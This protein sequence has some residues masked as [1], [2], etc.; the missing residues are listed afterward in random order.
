MRQAI[1]PE[2]LAEAARATGFSPAIRAGDFLFLTGATGAAA[3]GTM[4]PTAPEQAL[5]ALGKV[6]LVLAEEGATE[7][8]IVELTSYHTDIDADFSGI[9]GVLDDFFTAPLPAWTAVE[10]A[11]L[12]RPGARVEFRVVAHHPKRGSR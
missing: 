5:N 11:G 6:Q 8:D 10:I 4:P 3:D 7:A 9:Q 12:R 2:S 1:I